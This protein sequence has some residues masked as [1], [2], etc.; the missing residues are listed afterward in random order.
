MPRTESMRAGKQIE[1]SRGRVH[2]RSHNNLSDHF[3]NGREEVNY[4]PMRLVY[5]Q[6]LE[7]GP[8]LRSS[9]S[10]SAQLIFPQSLFDCFCD[11]VH[12]ALNNHLVSTIITLTN[13]NGEN[14]LNPSNLKCS[15]NPLSQLN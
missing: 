15:G 6:A 2:K 9:G 12:R 13:H 1:L 4:A 10:V 14:E 8:V 5:I 11:P 7:Q 3:G